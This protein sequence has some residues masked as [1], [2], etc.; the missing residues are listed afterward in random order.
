MDKREEKSEEEREEEE[1]EE[2]KGRGTGGED[3]VEKMVEDFSRNGRI[4]VDEQCNS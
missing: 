4:F 1:S 2:V 3:M